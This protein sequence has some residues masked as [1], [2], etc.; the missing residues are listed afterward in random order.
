MTSSFRKGSVNFINLLRCYESAFRDKLL[1]QKI[2]FVRAY[3]A[4]VIGKIEFFTILYSI[5]KQFTFRH[6]AL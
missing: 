3:T 2:G 6:I 5:S 1:R 4:Q